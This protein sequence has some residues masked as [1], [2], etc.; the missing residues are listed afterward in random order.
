MPQQQRGSSD[1]V[2][3]EPKRLADKRKCFF[4]FGFISAVAVFDITSH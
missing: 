1:C 2:F 4:L 3:G